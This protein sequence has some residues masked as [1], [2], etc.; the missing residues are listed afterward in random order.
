MYIINKHGIFHSIPD[1]MGL[2]AGARQ[3]TA[4][5]VAD[6]TADDQ[7]KKAAI[8]A[9]KQQAK[10]DRAQ[11]VVINHAPAASVEEPTVTEPDKGK[12]KPDGKP[13]A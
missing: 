6:W 5:E 1:D 7:A 2:P 13:T 4:K 11:M 8:K 10:E 3:A 9:A 12:G